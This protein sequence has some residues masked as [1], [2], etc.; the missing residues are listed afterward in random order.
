L[1]I[2]IKHKWNVKHAE[3]YKI[4]AI[5]LFIVT[6]FTS[7]DNWNIKIGNLANLIPKFDNHLQKC[8]IGFSVNSVFEKVWWFEIEK[9]NYLYCTIIWFDFIQKCGIDI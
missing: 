3:K 4:V 1:N 7:W 8:W 5:N 9:F 6:G 2:S